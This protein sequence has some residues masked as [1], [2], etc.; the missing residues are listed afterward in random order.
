MAF[1]CK[2][3]I[4]VYLHR[5]HVIAVESLYQQRELQTELFEYTVAYEIA[6]IHLNQF[7][8]IVAL[9]H[10]VGCYRD[11]SLHTR[12]VPAFAVT[13]RLVCMPYLRTFFCKEGITAPDTLLQPRFEFQRIQH[14]L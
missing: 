13:F 10:A 12:Y 3:I 8:K 9:E 5:Q 6:H 1:G 11:I 4:R 7:L 14:D 2:R